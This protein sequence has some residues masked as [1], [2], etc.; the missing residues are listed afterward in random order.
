[1]IGTKVDPEIKYVKIC[2]FFS[3]KNFKNLKNAYFLLKKNN[4]IFECLELQNN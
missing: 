1:M 4:I 3:Q 2:V